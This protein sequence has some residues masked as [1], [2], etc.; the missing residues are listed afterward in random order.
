MQVNQIVKTVSKT[1]LIKGLQAIPDKI[2]HIIFIQGN[3]EI[4]IKGKDT[5]VITK[6]KI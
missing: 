2:I 4:T 6:S 1:D 3:P 5:T